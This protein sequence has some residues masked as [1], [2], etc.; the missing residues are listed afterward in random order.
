MQSWRGATVDDRAAYEWWRRRDEGGP[1]VEDTSWDREVSTV[2]Q[3]YL[4]AIEQDLVRGNPIRQRG[5]TVWSPWTRGPGRREVRQVP[6]EA[7]HTGP[8]QE[9]KWLPPASYRLCGS[10][11]DS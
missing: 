2:N 3:F 5:A 6:A 7:S 1:R 4:W 11:S 8:R 9:V 10:I